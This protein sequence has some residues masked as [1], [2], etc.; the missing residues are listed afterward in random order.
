VKQHGQRS[1][2][3]LSKLIC[4]SCNNQADRTEKMRETKTLYYKFTNMNK[5]M[6]SFYYTEV[7]RNILIA[8]NYYRAIQ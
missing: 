8:L 3:A 1:H 2:Y 6:I 7:N 4:S 5:F